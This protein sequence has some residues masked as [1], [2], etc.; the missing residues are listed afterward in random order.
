MIRKERKIMRAFGRR[1]AAAALALG[2]GVMTLAGC[3]QKKL[4]GTQT[5]VTVNGENVTVGTLSFEAHYDAALFYSYYGAYIGNTGYFNVVSDEETGK[6]YGDMTVDSVLTQLE[7]DVIVSQHAADYGVELSEEQKAAIDAAAQA[8]I[9]KNAADVR[10]K[11][12]ASK[13]DIVYSMT[14]DTIRSLMMEPMA[15]DVDTEVSDEEAQQT[16]VS[17]ITVATATEDDVETAEDATDEEKQAAIEAENAVRMAKMQTILTNLL[18]ADNAA[19]ADLQEFADAVDDTLYA[20]N[21]SFSTNDEA[22]TAVNQAVADAART[23]KDG[24]VYESVITADDGAHYYILR[25]DHVF[26]EEATQNK[27]D[28]VVRTR[29]QEQFDKM[30]ADWVAA[31]EVSVNESAVA[32]IKLTDS[33]PFVFKAAA[34]ES[35]G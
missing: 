2:L 5:A 23:L 17:Y 31:A 18:A 25:V 33:E 11:I 12:G 20:Y 22:P 29:K 32:E 6:T 1:A 21:T 24:E 10:N 30:V 14:L 9:D 26:D 16:S 28:S 35:A 19:E 8:Y 3:G 27:K 7:E 15:A 34:E 4:D 13:E